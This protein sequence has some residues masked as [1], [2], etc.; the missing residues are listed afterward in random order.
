MSNS[1]IDDNAAAGAGTETETFELLN[2]EEE[3]EVLELPKVG[4]TDAGEKDEGE[5]EDESESDEDELKEIEDEIKEP[6]EDEDIN[7]LVTPVRF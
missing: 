5:S 1:P 6:S 2:T 3:P 7:E 4:K